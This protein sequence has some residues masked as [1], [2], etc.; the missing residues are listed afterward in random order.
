[1]GFDYDEYLTRMAALGVAWAADHPEFDAAGGG[2]TEPARLAAI[3]T[4]IDPDGVAE[5][6]STGAVA[7]GRALAAR[8]ACA[9][10]AM[11]DAYGL[12]RPYPV[13]DGFGTDADYEDAMAACVRVVRAG[14]LRMA[15]AMRDACEQAGTDAS[16]LERRLDA[17]L[18]YDRRYLAAVRERVAG[19]H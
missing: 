4:D 15:D 16:E 12:P 2:M 13:R 10:D 1:M 14:D 5:A 11:A 19:R 6:V 9:L 3:V 17:I 7:D 18:P 8:A